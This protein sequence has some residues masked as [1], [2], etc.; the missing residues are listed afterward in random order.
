MAKK[1]RSREKQKNKPT[2]LK[3]TLIAHQFHKE[4][5]APLVKQYRRAMCLKNYDAARDFFQQLTEAR[6][7]HR[8][9]LHRKEKVRIK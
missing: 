2:K 7:H 5:I 6:Q 3:Y 4:T 1:K 8:L 9:L